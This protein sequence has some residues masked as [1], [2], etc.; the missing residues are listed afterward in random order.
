MPLA[1]VI[2][3]LFPM[4]P[5]IHH[6][7]AQSCNSAVTNQAERI[8]QQNSFCNQE[9]NEDEDFHYRRNPQE[10]MSEYG[11]PKNWSSVFAWR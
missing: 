6:L 1:Q 5:Q 7:A 2:A 8:V 4:G 11:I 9:S 3:L 10:I